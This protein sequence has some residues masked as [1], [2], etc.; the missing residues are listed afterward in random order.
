MKLYDE[1]ASWFHLL[2]AAEEYVEEAAFARDLLMTAGEAP[3]RTVLELGSGGGNNA[4][5]MK[6]SFQLTLTDISPGMLELSRGI[7]PE[8]E[9]IQGDMRTLRLGRTFDGVFIHD[10]IC[11]MTT[12]ADLLRALETAAAH[13]RPGG[14]L[15]IAPDDVRENFRPST[16]DGGH[17]GPERALRYLEWHWDPDPDDST[18]TVDYAYLLREPDGSVHVEH[19]RHVHGL[20]SRDTWLRLLREA[21]FAEPRV[22]RDSYERDLFVARRA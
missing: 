9:H 20:F 11:Y 6:A 1:L 17:D 18:T 22:V 10:A 3:P 4:S 13:C 16:G 2:T 14:A 15:V 21:G 7:N 19:D 5:H 8:C 12:E